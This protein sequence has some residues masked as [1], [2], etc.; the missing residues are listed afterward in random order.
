MNTFVIH[1]CAHLWIF[2]IDSFEENCLIKRNVLNIPN[3][4]TQVSGLCPVILLIL[5][6]ERT[7]LP[8]VC[9]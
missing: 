4:C 5:V 1:P 9:K 3:C 6:Y 2:L 7:L 8:V